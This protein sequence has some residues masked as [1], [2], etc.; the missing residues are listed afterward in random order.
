M[1]AEI[2][3]QGIEDTNGIAWRFL[4]TNCKSM[5]NLQP[6]ANRLYREKC[7]LHAGQTYTLQCDSIGE[8]WKTNYLVIENSEYC[9]YARNMTLFNITIT[10]PVYI[11]QNTVLSIICY[12]NFYSVPVL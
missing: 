2:E 9:K 4:D 10:G 7:A 6:T 1:S 8:G 3:L 11:L 5:P 12:F